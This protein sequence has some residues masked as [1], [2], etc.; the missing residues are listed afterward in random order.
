MKPSRGRITLGPYLGESLG[1]IVNEHVLSRGVSDSA[2]ILDI[3]HGPSVGDPYQAPAPAAP[4]L[5][6][7]D[8][9]P[10]KLRIALSEDSLL[11][12]KVDPDCLAAVRETAR[13]CEQLGHEVV[14]DAPKLDAEVYDRKYRRFWAMTATR[15]IWP[16]AQATGCNPHDLAEQV[17]P[18]NQY[19]FSI[20]SSI[21]AADYVQDLAWFHRTGRDLSG[22]LQTYD[23][24]LTPTLGSPPPK[25]GHFDGRRHSCETVMDRFMAFLAFTTFANMAGLPSMSVPLFW[26]SAGLPIGSQLTAAFGAEPLLFRLAGQLERARP[27]AQ[28]RAPIWA[29]SSIPASARQ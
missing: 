5:P 15:A 16:H 27:W 21:L 11:G 23:V 4:Y 2:A 1:G 20:G 3:S 22:F 7:V 25:L 19:L 18:F 24:W 14:L 10:G 12:T 13:L 28:R 26:S 9:E 29:G 6:E 17:E 8:R